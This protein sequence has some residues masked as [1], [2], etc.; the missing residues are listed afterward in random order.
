MQVMN[1]YNESDHIAVKNCRNKACQQLQAFLYINNAA[2]TKYGLLMTG[3]QTQQ[4][5]WNNQYPLTIVE[6]N[7]VLNEHKFNNVNA[8]KQVEIND[9]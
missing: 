5:L 3:L 4:S 6:V 9:F 1:G 2:K 8:W 7:N